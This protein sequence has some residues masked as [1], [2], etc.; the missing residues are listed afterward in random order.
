MKKALKPVLEA[1]KEFTRIGLLA[2]IPVLIDGLNNNH[3]DWRLI[4]VSF[5]IAVLKAIDKY[6]HKLGREYK[7]DSLV[8]GLTRF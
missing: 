1:I 5:A 4:G 2:A 8:K 7:K 6:L 3:I